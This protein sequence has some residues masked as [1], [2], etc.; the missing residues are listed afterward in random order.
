MGSNS[1]TP[2]YGRFPTSQVLTI[3]NDNILIDCGEGAQIRMSE[4]KVKRSRIKH[5]LISHLHGDHIY[6]LPGFLGSLS[7]HSRKDPVT[8]FGPIGIKEFLETVL[9]LSESRMGYELSIKEL[10][11]KGV[12]VVLDGPSYKIS[13]FPVNHRIP[14]YGYL[15]EEKLKEKNIRKEVIKEYQ[16]SIDEIIAIKNGGDLIRDD[17][18]IANEELVHPQPEPRSYAFCADTTVEGW[19]SSHL[20]G[21]NT[22]YF[23][24]TYLDEL[25]AQAHER[26]HATAKE[27]GLFAKKHQ[28]KQLIIGH[29]S[30]RYKD[31]YPLYEE[32]KKEHENTLMGYDGMMHRIL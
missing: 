30:S 27:A 17:V 22:I 32:A 1:A 5:V 23:E 11:P 31:P 8:V 29:Y 26:K 13:M 12:E 14:T 15:C 3:G 25:R 4:Y 7:H 10:D 20:N 16:L 28:V 21:I 6:G 9:R 2:A 24:T 18:Q 19:D